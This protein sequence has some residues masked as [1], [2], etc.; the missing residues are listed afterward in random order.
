MKK[1]SSRSFLLLEM[2][3]ALTLV[4]LCIMPFINVPFRIVQDELLAIERIELQH[5]SDNAFAHIKQLIYLK[6]IPWQQICQAK[7]SKVLVLEEKVVLPFKEL[8][9]KKIQMNCFLYSS[10][11]KSDNEQEHRLVTVE[12]YFEKPKAKFL[13]FP[14]KKKKKIKFTYQLLIK[15][16]VKASTPLQNQT[17]TPEASSQLAVIHK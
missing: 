13:F 15:S 7:E 14:N 6:D 16:V 12:V 1:I 10:G 8:A 5:I 11:K 17:I 3:I 9:E 4:M 2:L